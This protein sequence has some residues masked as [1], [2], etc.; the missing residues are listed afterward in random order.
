SNRSRRAGSSGGATWL[1]ATTD[2]PS[3]S[4]PPLGRLLAA[5]WPPL[6]RVWSPLR[7][8]SEPSVSRIDHDLQPEMSFG[9]LRWE[10]GRPVANNDGKRGR[11]QGFDLG[12][13]A[14][15]A[16]RRMRSSPWVW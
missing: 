3:A 14:P 10:D 15:G 1:R 4:W 5:S 9:E 13:G 7:T 16:P 6:G 8:P 11:W 2:P 12:G